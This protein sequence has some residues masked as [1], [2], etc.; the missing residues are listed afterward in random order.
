MY[1][2]ITGVVVACYAGF[3]YTLVGRSYKNTNKKNAD[4]F[5]KDLK[6][7]TGLVYISMGCSLVLMG[8]IMNRFGDKF[9]KY[10]LASFGTII[11]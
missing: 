2:T 7:H 10:R 9:N 6:F 3:L 4:E 1:Y 11:V 8:F 5:S